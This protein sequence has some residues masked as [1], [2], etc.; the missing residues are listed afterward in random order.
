MTTRNLGPQIR[1]LQEILRSYGARLRRQFDQWTSRMRQAEASGAPVSEATALAGLHSDSPRER[2][3]SAAALGRNPGRSDAALVALTEALTDAEEFVRWQAAEALAAQDAGRVFP[4]LADLLN[5]THP[6]KR[7]GAATALGRLGSEAATLTLE[8]RL[9]EETDPEVR[10]AI[11]AALGEAGDPNLAPALEPLLEDA[12]PDLRR[13]VA[14]ALGRLGNP[15]AATALAQA[16][17]QPSQPLLV[18]R[19]IAAALVRTA[20]PDAQEPLVAALADADPQVRAYAARAL[21]LAGSE[22]AYDALRVLEG[23]ESPVLHGT[24]G[25][26]A[27]AALALLE[28]RQRRTGIASGAAE[29]AV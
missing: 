23:D 28:Q 20:H 5:N 14:T 8:R 24:V 22:P 12:D 6:L 9:R 13:A 1:D 3:E 2:W 16:L 4:M 11:V 19:A 18:R 15:A 21:G 26:A 10:A 29:G 25:D 7:A 17:A 27:T